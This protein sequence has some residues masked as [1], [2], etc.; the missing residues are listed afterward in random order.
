M[1]GSVQDYTA[2]RALN[3]IKQ[4]TDKDYDQD[5][6]TMAEWG[7]EFERINPGVRFILETENGRSVIV[8]ALLVSS[9][10]SC[11]LVPFLCL[12][13]LLVS[14]CP[15]C[16]LVCPRALLVSIL[17][18][19]ALVTDRFKRC[20]V[21]LTNAIHLAY[22][23]GLKVS[24]VDAC[25]SKH[26]IYRD[27]RLHILTTY[28]GDNH[29]IPL[30]WMWA[31]TES[32]DTYEWFAEQCIL[33]GL[34]RY[35]GRASVLFSDRQ[36]GI[37]KF[38]DAFHAI[39]LKCFWHVIKNCRENIK[40]C[41]KTFTSAIAWEL[42]RAHNRDTFK[43]VLRR[44]KAMC[45]EAAEYFNNQQPHSSLFQ[46]AFNDNNYVTHNGVTQIAAAHHSH[47]TS[48]AAESCNWAFEPAR[49]ESPYR[50][51]N[52]ILR[53]IGEKLAER[54]KFMN[55]WITKKHMLTPYA[56]NLWETQVV[57]HACAPC[58]CS[59]LVSLTQLLCPY[60]TLVPHALCPRLRLP[61]GMVT[62]S[63]TLVGTFMTSRTR[64][65]QTDLIWRSIWQ[66]QSAVP[67][68]AIIDSRAGT[69]VQYFPTK[70]Q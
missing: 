55:N 32:G 39:A 42:Q 46:Y 70:M 8:C 69:C 3:K 2:R 62:M 19:R 30:A 35:L 21:S 26:S 18:P 54:H 65:C 44:L 58:L 22:G 40:G 43:S 4:C 31:E 38:T 9:C 14:S 67:T 64:D 10:P 11:A 28:D 7:R 16:A 34:A 49:Y 15:S 27:G 66:I 23:V 13:A 47:G 48:Q 20:F 33:A 12:P 1:A 50:S 60:K 5:W 29:L 57:P 68:Y 53:W 59:M 45:P 61:S 56:F 6:S 51:N 17:C 41:G 36:K 24:A 52:V 63:S 37:D 25:H